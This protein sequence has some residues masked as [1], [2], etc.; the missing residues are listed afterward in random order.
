MNWLRV[1]TA[2]LEIA[3][4]LAAFAANWLLQSTLLIVTGLCIAWLARRRGAAIQS[5][6]YRTT[7]AAVIVCP[8]ATLLLSLNGVN[9]WSLP[10]PAAWRYVESESPPLATTDTAAVVAPPQADATETGDFANAGGPS[11]DRRAF[12]R[13]P[14]DAWT[15]A[16][17]PL[18]PAGAVPLSSGEPEPITASATPASN[19]A[20]T[21]SVRAPTVV[22]EV[23]A[24][25]FAA[26]VISLAWIV[27]ATLLVA[28]LALGWRRLHR[29]LRQA[30]P[31]DISVQD[32]CQQA[33][34][35]V[36]VTA[37]KVLSSPY[38]ISPCLVGVF[39]GERGALG[40]LWRSVKNDA[41]STGTSRNATEGVPYRLTGDQQPELARR[42]R[43]V[44]LLP[45]LT[46]TLPLRDV[47]I[48]ELA[49]LR[50]G[51]AGWN[52]L[53][54]LSEALFF[55]QPL[56]WLLSLR[57]EASAEDVCDDYVVQFGGDRSQYA[58]GLLEIAE[59][60]TTPIG[61]TAV[62]MVS[63]RSIL[64]R[65]VTRILD[66]SRTLSTRA[67][68]LLL[69]LVIA[70]GLAGATVVGF[71][72]LGSHPPAIAEPTPET[73]SEPQKSAA[74]EKH[75]ETSQSAAKDATDQKPAEA[76][77]EAASSNPVEQKTIRGQVLD[78]DGHPFAGA[79]IY[80]I[81]HYSS[82]ELKPLPLG[83]AKSGDDG[84]FELS[85]PNPIYTHAAQLGRLS[86]TSQVI[87]ALAD[88]FGPG[89]ISTEALDGKPLTLRLVR[90]DVPIVGRV[91]DLEGRP[92]A[93]VRVSTLDVMSAKG[94]DLSAW[95]EAVK[96]GEVNW[97]AAKHLDSSLP[98]FESTAAPIV[99]DAQGRYRVS[100]IGRE[101][102]ARLR[103][104]GPNIAYTEVDV[105]TRRIK[106]LRMVTRVF[107]NLTRPLYGADLDLPAAPTQ[108]I[109]GTVRDADT[110][111]PVAGV[112]VGNNNWLPGIVG[113]R[114]VRTVTDKA[115]HYRL[116]G[117]PKT[118]GIELLAVPDDDQPLFMQ[119]VAVPA[120]ATLEPVTVDINLHRGIWITGRVTDKGTGR[121][122]AAQVRYLPFLS[123]EFAKQRAPEF[124]LENGPG[125]AHGVGFHD[126]YV[127]AADGAYRLVGLP[128]RAIVGAICVT[129]P[130]RV[131]VGAD[132]IAGGP[133]E[134]GHF[135]TYH[136]NFPAGVKWPNS[137]KEINPPADAKSFACDLEL[138]P[139]ET[140]RVAVVDANG[141][142]LAGYTVVGDKEFSDPAEV[143]PEAAFDVLNL[144]PD[145][146]RTVVVRHER[147]NL[148]K[149]VKLR[150]HERPGR[151]LTVKLEP[152]ATV[153]GR[154]LKAGGD[155]IAAANVNAVVHPN[156]DFAAQ[157]AS[158]TTD[159]E[160]RFEFTGV[161]T[162]CGYDLAVVS[163][164]LSASVAR[165]LQLASGETNDLGDVTVDNGDA[166]S[167]AAAAKVAQPPSAVAAAKAADDT[168]AKKP[169]TKK[170]VRGK[171]AS[172]SRRL[173]GRVVDDKTQPI[174]GAH[175]RVYRNYWLSD[176]GT[177]GPAPTSQWLADTRCDANGRFSAEFEPLSAAAESKA[178]S[179]GFSES[180]GVFVTAKGF[181][182]GLQHAEPAVKEQ[183]ELHLPRDFH[184]IEGR[185]L[186]LEGRAVQ[187]ARVAV[188]AVGIFDG[189]P[190]KL[191]DWLA[192][193]RAGGAAK[194]G[195][196]ELPN[197]VM[198]IQFDSFLNPFPTATTD[199]AGRFT[200]AS[201]GA[202]RV[203]YLKI[204]GA[205]VAGAWL[206]VVT[207]DIEPLPL[208]SGL[209]RFA[210]QTCYGDRCNIVVPPE[211]PIRGVVRDAET[212]EPLKNVEV[213]FN[214]NDDFFT[215]NSLST[216]T[217]ADGRY[218]LRG[219]AK[220]FG[221]RE[222]IELRVIPA[223]DQAYF[224][225]E[226][227]VPRQA[228]LDA[229]TCDVPLRRAIMLRGKVTDRKTG[230]GVR[231]A[232]RYYPFL[233]NAEAARYA[234]FKPGVRKIGDDD[235]YAT[236][237]EG[238]FA[239]P[240]VAG[241][242]VLTVVAER[243]D[244]Y[245]FAEGADTIAGFRRAD[246]N[247]LN[248]YHL[249]D[250]NR[251]NAYRDVN[252][253][254]DAKELTLNVE[255]APLPV[256][257]LSLV[258]EIGRELRGVET[259]GLAPMNPFVDHWSNSWREPRPTSSAELFGPE[260]GETRETLFLHRALNLG[261]MIR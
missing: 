222:V 42:A 175:V 158:V 25:G 70:G 167:N 53:A 130:Y 205:Q 250:L 261:A 128:G 95:L 259:Q 235:R 56:V 245:A 135:P 174:A 92:V 183:I 177:S 75:L 120:T 124:G 44:I 217:G 131:G 14:D 156:Q 63:L 9:G 215:E 157:L 26:I 30:S 180:I 186:N 60:S 105:V 102:V 137:M 18:P 203:A 153:K 96:Q 65:R 181:G 113:N 89:F 83:E 6:I 17:A 257:R 79:T 229:V 21:S 48:H 15:A 109:V 114:V 163:V 238:R 242:G 207:R 132:T 28:R 152:C 164:G 38:I 88:G 51:D 227:N 255:L 78:P 182:F 7:L 101:R 111:Q 3:G 199:A 5:A 45:E 107:D 80:A 106:P 179:R 256:T 66:S 192:Q 104:T 58:R 241:R 154:L 254:A 8:L 248:V 189:E 193:V 34:A 40:A 82:P 85:Y 225:T 239:I 29:M 39:C 19:A 1:Q 4:A 77:N 16:R 195:V 232:V 103:F 234:N 81:G 22:F 138:D 200:I 119:E 148:G 86:G 194:G 249:A 126:R 220:P 176:G 169:E 69:A 67:G 168:E 178:K 240:A 20:S 64:A 209:L 116:E 190:D 185:V 149:V 188:R 206:P 147:L 50:R 214:F 191:D 216:T 121:P 224:R 84:R 146:T 24:F 144:G 35:L 252:I 140:I 55:F 155:P 94:N 72:G 32:A 97:Q 37:P 57:L 10:M 93:G 61:A 43:A 145:E 212:G 244:R 159:Q 202:D 236:D 36:G 172:G 184:P 90:D 117:L 143:R 71:V 258:D 233:S 160:G 108:A 129:R 136:N 31:A 223:V 11:W 125:M 247:R 141:K 99:T 208:A 243:G 123:N 115:G 100:G 197:G 198:T 133:D 170:L 59:L 12:A 41:T 139:G 219:L 166:A 52:L 253:P 46:P 196:T 171:A 73:T 27:G 54:R 218:E 134:H 213:R 151:S 165:N 74:N 221:E 142:P 118:D 122:V 226:L 237:A 260:A 246:Q 210:S 127:T 33:A 2:L 251:D 201:V 91:L 23:F 150:V 204:E 162:G 112:V 62:A 231:A 230:A 87:A 13:R 47:L 49:H 110:G 161:P 98:E 228:G 173:S 211:Q 76:Q 187:G 68:N